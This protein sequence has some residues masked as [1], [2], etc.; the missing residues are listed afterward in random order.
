MDQSLSPYLATSLAEIAPLELLRRECQERGP[1]G[2]HV[3]AQIPNNSA[4][5]V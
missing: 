5:G 2:V 4:T 1:V 3:L